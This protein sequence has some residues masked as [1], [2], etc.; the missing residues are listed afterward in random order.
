MECHTEQCGFWA[1]FRTLMEVQ[2][3]RRLIPDYG[4]LPHCREFYLGESY[5]HGGLEAYRSHKRRML[6]GLGA[7]A[8]VLPPGSFY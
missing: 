8:A 5:R 3:R 2:L 4:Y 1:L 6:S 7:A